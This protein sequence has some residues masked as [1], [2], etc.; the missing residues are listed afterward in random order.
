L[1]STVS[2]II[3]TAD[4]P[5]SLKQTLDSL[6]Q[7]DL[8]A[9]IT[10][11]VLIVDN[12]PNKSLAVVE[13]VDL[14]PVTLRYIP[15]TRCGLTFARNTGLS[16]STGDIIAFTD[17][18][19]RFRVDW[20][21]KLTAPILSGEADAVAGAIAIAPHLMR[22]WMR[23]IHRSFLAEMDGFEPTGHLSMVGANMAFSRK[24]L[25]KLSGFDVNLGAGRLGF[26]DDGLF[27]EQLVAEGFKLTF[28]PEAEVEHH[29]DPSRL[30]RQSLL[31]HARGIGRSEAY[32]AHHWRHRT[33][34]APKLHALRKKLALSLWRLSH[35]AATKID[36]G[37]FEEEIYTVI[38]QNFYSHYAAIRQEPRIYQRQGF[39][40]VGRTTV[41]EFYRSIKDSMSK[42]SAT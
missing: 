33:I 5:N 27:S 26:V 6:A 2:I 30:T 29:F 32:V 17:D 39:R 35:R 31:E 15:E 18:D 11:E 9:D 3:C 41:G 38:A 24:V 40:P 42:G 25:C 13:S 34:F 23:D 20:I 12:R 4:R 22:H 16:Q 1:P 28:C 19:I 10:A 36:E 21:E 14:S 8:P 37:C 7:V